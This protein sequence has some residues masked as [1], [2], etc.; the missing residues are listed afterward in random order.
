MDTSYHSPTTFSDT[1]RIF[2]C[3]FIVLH[4]STFLVGYIFAFSLSL[5][6][7][8]PLYVLAP[9]ESRRL[10]FVSVLNKQQTNHW[11]IKITQHYPGVCEWDRKT[12]TILNHHNTLGERGTESEMPAGQLLR[13]DQKKP[14]VPTLQ[15]DSSSKEFWSGNHLCKTKCV[16]TKQKGFKDM[17]IKYVLEHNQCQ[18]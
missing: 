11:H 16:K 7:V 8:Y 10:G 1:F 18:V 3:L 5:F 14:E 4:W 12:P 15:T 2:I 17:L 6:P 9:I 13:N